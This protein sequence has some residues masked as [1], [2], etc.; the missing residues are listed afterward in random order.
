MRIELWS[1]SITLLAAGLLLSAFKDL[2][3]TVGTI[4][5]LKRDIEAVA[6]PTKEFRRL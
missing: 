6:D 2:L 4:E 3:F 1:L 5:L